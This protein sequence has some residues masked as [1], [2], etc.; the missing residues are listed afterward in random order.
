MCGMQK[1]LSVIKATNKAIILADLEYSHTGTDD[2]LCL[3]SFDLAL[4]TPVEILH[5]VTLRVYKYLVNHLFKEVLKGNNAS[6]VKLSDLLKQAK[7]F[8][9]FTRTFRKKLRHSESYLDKKFKILV[10]VLPPI[11]NTEVSM[12]AKPF[13]ELC[14]LSSLLFIQEVDSD[15]DQYLNN[16]DNTARC[17]VVFFSLT[18]KTHLLLHLKEDIKRFDCAFH[19]ETEKV[20]YNAVD[21]LTGI[22]PL[23]LE[24]RTYSDILPVEAY[25]LTNLQVLK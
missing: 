8:R 18:L 3:Q 24:S 4:D 11:L 17:L 25:G 21:A 13:M 6:Q 14:I 10:Q 16:V 5:T 9:N 23:S 7:G 1:P 22:L 12:I 15:F 19:F 20:T 2:L